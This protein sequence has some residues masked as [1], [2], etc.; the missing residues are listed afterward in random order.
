MRS[1]IG[2]GLTVAVLS[3]LF[4][5][6]AQAQDP[7][8]GAIT[9]TAGL[10]IPTLYFFRG[11]RQETDPKLT[12]WP[13]GD[14][15]LALF[16]GDGGVRSVGVNFGVWNSLHTGS[17][18]L[19]GPS[20]KLHYEEDFYATLNLGFGAGVALGTTFTAY[21][22]WRSSSATRTLQARMGAIRAPISS[23]ASGPAGLS[24]AAA[25]RLQFR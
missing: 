1:W 19:D 17:S 22:C 6:P 2:L 16:A 7:N 25:P 4:V 24:A 9:L 5:R 11:I 21:T 13:Y 3:A 12:L 15:G 20:D 23:S 14:V 8:P 10:D 18:G